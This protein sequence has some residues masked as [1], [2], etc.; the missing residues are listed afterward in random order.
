MSQCLLFGEQYG[1]RVYVRCTQVKS[2]SSTFSV[3]TDYTFR[4]ADPSSLLEF[5]RRIIFVY[6]TPASKC[7][8]IDFGWIIYV[9][10]MEN[11]TIDSIVICSG[12][13]AATANLLARNSVLTWFSLN[14]LT[15]AWMSTFFIMTLII[16]NWKQ[17]LYYFIRSIS[18]IYRSAFRALMHI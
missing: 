5:R 17:S 8:L 18:Y 11:V 2:C 9:S 4:R 1:W 7:L 3:S 15:Y 13:F 6:S 14:V 12:H 16:L 10:T